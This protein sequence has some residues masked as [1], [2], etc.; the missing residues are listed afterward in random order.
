MRG[1]RTAAWSLAV[2]SPLV[3]ALDSSGLLPSPDA[4]VPAWI[5][6]FALLGVL[7]P[8]A[9]GLGI[10]LRQPRNAIAWILLAGAVLAAPWPGLV[11][12]RGWSLQIAR[13]SWPLLYAWPIAVAF[14]F[15]DGRLLGRRWSIAAATGAF[16]FAGF[17]GVAMFDRSA[18]A[19]PDEHVLNP[20]AHVIFPHRLEWIWVPLW[21][22]IL[23]SLLAGAVAI[24]LR[25]RRSRGIER[26]QTL[27]LAW[28]A[29]LIPLGLVFCVGAHVAFGGPGTVLFAFLLAMEAA[30]AVAVGVAV[31]R[32]RLYAIERLSTA[33]SS[34]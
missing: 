28:A 8:A 7:A 11:P 18:F 6:P 16:C 20:M 13:A 32:Y 10:A 23:A 33:R 26:L 34:T 4:G 15:P 29:A 22:G 3:V 21:L 27:W 12:S 25:L 9:V 24:R 17:M 2:A 19:S 31:V 5:W 14:V 1:T 30:V